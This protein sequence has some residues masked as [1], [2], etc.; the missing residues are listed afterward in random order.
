[1][2][3]RCHDLDA[4]FDGELPQDQADAFRD[5]LLTCDRCQTLL[6]G[7]MQETTAARGLGAASARA[8]QP[9]AAA[10]ASAP[11]APAARSGGRRIVVYAAPLATAAALLLWLVHH[12][13]PELTL[14]AHTDP[15]GAP[16]SRSTPEPDGAAPR[17]RRR[18]AHKGE[19]LQLAVRGE[20]HR[21]LWVYLDKRLEVACPGDPRCRD[22][23]GELTLALTL[24][25]GAY[26]V[27]ALGSAA[28]IPPP[29]PSATDDQIQ[30]DPPDGVELR[31]ESYDVD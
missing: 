9:V 31:T 26:T 23:G 27:L 3:P 12:D 7:R 18:T 1:M 8:G 29:P 2:T 22:A 24:T 21:A 6:L 4:F 5:H 25:R 20:R 17:A 11:V 19:V 15:A 10:P 13:E 30:A 14:T 28:A 16:R